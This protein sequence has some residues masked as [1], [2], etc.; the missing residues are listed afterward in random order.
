MPL[1]PNT[2]RGLLSI[3]GFLAAVHGASAAEP[4]SVPS[5]KIDAL[6][7]QRTQAPVDRFIVRFASGSGIS[8]NAAATLQHVAAAIASDTTVRATL[9]R[10][11]QPTRYVRR[12]AVGSDVIQVPTKL[13]ASD[14][15]AFMTALA[16]D[17]AV[18]YV[19]PDVMDHAFAVPLPND[20]LLSQKQWHM[21]DTP[22]GV[23]APDAWPTST[24][25]GITVAVID[26]GITRHPDLDT[27]LADTSYDFISQAAVSGRATDGRAQGAWDLGDWSAPGQCSMD[28]PGAPSS[29]HGTHVA[30]TIAE[31]ANN[32]IGGVGV[33]YDAKVLPIRVL[34]H[35][36]GL[37]S[38]I[39]DAIEWASGGTVDGAP[40]TNANPADVI[41]MSLGGYGTCSPGSAYG[42]A[43]ADAIRRGTV[44]VAAAGN[45]DV[46]ASN[47]TPANCSGVIVVG[48]VGITTRRAFY[49]DWGPRVDIAA[50][51]GGIYKDDAYSGDVVDDGFVWQTINDGK[52]GPQ[53][54]VYG[55]DAGTSMASP[56]VAGVVALVLSAQAKAGV[57]RL[58]PDQMRL[59][60]QQTARP[61]T[62]AADPD[63]P[64]GSGIVDAGAAV[65]RAVS[66]SV[67]VQALVNRVPANNQ[68]SPG[69]PLYY[70]VAV[71]AGTDVVTFRTFGGIG[72]VDLYLGA[73][74]QTPTTTA[75]ARRSAHAGNAETITLTAPAAGTYY[76]MV[77]SDRAFSGVT[78]MTAY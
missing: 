26:T 71:P 33:A 47:S 16:K 2:W 15:T 72:D 32:G 30:G 53:N 5:T 4:A 9:R 35:C 70:S 17:P 7:M 10:F 42:T 78:V 37:R 65:Q 1:R 31:L 14:A 21:L 43:I 11:P 54:P 74:G 23:H 3:A 60:L 59:L 34:G 76:L 66:S 56:H 27:S 61:F 51:G 19:E 13:G 29:W 44:V 73:V 55:G 46:D 50:P 20:P 28:D 77:R 63:K 75:F 24:G 48:A 52:Q 22:A 45:D 67:P 41:N 62:I 38:D 18:L 57:P 58:T 25:K 8:G 6:S 39:A 69:A 40:G 49:S 12:L 68:G 36:G 64:I